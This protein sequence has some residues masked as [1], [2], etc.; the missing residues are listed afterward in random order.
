MASGLALPLATL[1]LLALPACDSAT[2]TPPRPRELAGAAGEAARGTLPAPAAAAPATAAAPAATSPVSPAARSRLT[3]LILSTPPVPDRQYLAQ[4]LRRDSA[5]NRCAFRVTAPE[6]EGKPLTAADLAEAIRQATARS[7]GVLMVEP[8]DAPEVRQALLEARSKGLPTVL[9]DRPLP[10]SSA[11]ETFPMIALDGFEA[12]ARELVAALTE[13]V[14][15][16]GYALDAPAAVL[17]HSLKD[18]YSQRRVDALTG[19]LRA[20]G[21]KFE[22]LNFADGQP[23]A[24]RA[25]SDH[26]KTHPNLSLALADD[27]F[28]VAGAAQTLDDRR[29]KKQRGF[30]VGGF[31]A[32]DARLDQ[33]VKLISHGLINRNTDGYSQKLMKLAVDLMERRS[34]PDRTTVELP[35]LRNPPDPEGVAAERAELEKAAA[36]GKTPDTP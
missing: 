28:G 34:V 16:S 12:R 25:L 10:A 33:F 31:A 17:V 15:L 13:D 29:L 18:F 24:F 9:V 5:P 27:E 4:F 11:A 3:E 14:K 23:G 19:A 2:F 6:P 35:I 30:I 26:L 7:T 32:T 1:V 21:W 36:K 20:A 8:I 22:V